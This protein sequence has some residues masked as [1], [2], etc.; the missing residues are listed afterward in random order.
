MGA[1]WRM[2]AAAGSHLYGRLCGQV[3]QCVFG[4]GE[5]RVVFAS[6]SG[7]P[8]RKK[9][10]AVRVTPSMCEL[11]AN[12]WPATA[13][14]ARLFFFFRLVAVLRCRAAPGPLGLWISRACSR[15]W[16]QCDTTI[17]SACWVYLCV[18]L[19]LGVATVNVQ[20]ALKCSAVRSHFESLGF[21]ATDIPQGPISCKNHQC[22]PFFFQLKLLFPT[23]FF[24][25]EN[26]IV[27]N[28][29]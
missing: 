9:F 18:L 2:R 23:R 19:T 22:Q 11:G 6:S 17:M 29:I 24:Q 28:T 14:L 26:E 20:A 13:R 10:R 8:L 15:V 1:I 7:A 12:N 5:R 27:M 4:V 25:G 16:H 21:P 3:F